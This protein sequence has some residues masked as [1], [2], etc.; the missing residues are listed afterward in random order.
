LTDTGS[1]NGTMLN[2]AKLVPNMRTTLAP[3]DV[4]RLGSMEFR[5]KVSDK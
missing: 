5:I 4:I 3:D 2:D 1:T